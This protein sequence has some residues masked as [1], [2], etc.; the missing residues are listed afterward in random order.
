MGWIALV[1][2]IAALIGVLACMDKI[3]FF[4]EQPPADAKTAWLKDAAPEGFKL[5]MDFSPFDTKNENGTISSTYDKEEPDIPE[6]P[7]AP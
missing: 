4:A 6:R 5:P 1:A 2:S 3:E 7:N